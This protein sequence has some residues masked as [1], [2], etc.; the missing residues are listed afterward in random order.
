MKRVLLGLAALLALGEAAFAQGPT[1]P[2][3]QGNTRAP[4]VMQMCMD[5]R[6]IAV[7]CPMADTQAD[8][9]HRFTSARPAD[10]P[11]VVS[12]SPNDACTP[13]PS[14]AL[15]ANQVIAIAQGAPVTLCS[16]NVSADSTLS[17][18][19]WWVMIY[20]AATAPADGAVTP[21]KC[22]AMT[23]GTTSYN[24]GFSGGAIKFRT[25]IVIG[26]GTNGC[27]TKAASTHAF[28]SG[29]FR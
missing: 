8:V 22:Y 23:A 6:G 28:I 10:R 20:D 13:V 24:A 1:Y 18:A 9:L 29:D 7:P 4:G 16:F 5:R 19:A 15:A 27:F 25:G 11:M 26:V 3:A 12:V 21:V 14:A 2:T 17:A